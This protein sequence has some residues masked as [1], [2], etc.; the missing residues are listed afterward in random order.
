MAPLRFGINALYLIPGEVGGT[1]TYLRGLLRGLAE[2]DQ[3]NQYFIF[4][5]RETGADLIPK[6]DGF[7]QAAVPVSAESRPLRIL[8]EQ[9]DLPLEAIRLRL[10]A[11]L[12]PG[13]TG[14]LACACPQ[15]TMFHDMQHK[16]HPEFFRW[17]DRPFW[18]FFLFGSAHIS[19]LLLAN[20]AATAR[21]VLRHYRLP[22]SK[23]RISPLGVDK[24]LFGLAER[25]RPERF[26]LTVSTLHPHKNLKRLLRA[27][28]NF[29]RARPDFRLVVCG[30]HG[31]ESVA[32]HEL[33]E[34]L[35]LQDSVDFPGWIP[36]ERLLDLFTRA[37]AFV[38]PSRFEG[39]GIPVLEAMAAGIPVAC[40]KIEPL[41]SNAG[42]AALLFDPHN[43]KALI[44][45]LER[46]VEDGELRA[47]L[48]EAGPRRAAQFT[49]RATAQ[50]TLDALTA[51][52][53]T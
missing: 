23:I 53:G 35:G 46:I 21:D 42:G 44:T 8:W 39:F 26:L 2:L 11:M 51:V 40:S 16:R 48:A 29:H 13:F 3:V 22:E 31:F 5:N 33:R 45:A 28:A 37:W 10:D 52:C 14:P 17:F 20:S 34:S 43:S 7:V 19:R 27:F 41:I 24:T 6:R 1:E 18:N 30:L 32:L 36:R 4:T 50:V 38:Y 12:N 25:R 15:V 49:W 9:L 47:Q